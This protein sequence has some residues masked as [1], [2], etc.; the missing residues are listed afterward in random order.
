MVKTYSVAWGFEWMLNMC[1]TIINV[2]YW[3][4]WK[5]RRCSI[6]SH[7]CVSFG[8]CIY[9][10]GCI[11]MMHSFEYTSRNWLKLNKSWMLNF[12]KFFRIINLYYLRLGNVKGDIIASHGQYVQELWWYSCYWIMLWYK[13]QSRGS[14]DE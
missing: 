5:M 8:Y 6:A 1:L 7:N 4:F 14:V 13:F 3:P 2:K 10:L 11:I 12:K 9:E